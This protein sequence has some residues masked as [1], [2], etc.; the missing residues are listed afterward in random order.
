MT[1]IKSG[2]PASLSICYRFY[3]WAFGIE[4]RPGNIVRAS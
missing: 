2:I 4:E 1:A 3:L